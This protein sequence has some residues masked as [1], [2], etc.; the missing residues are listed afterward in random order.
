MGKFE[1]FSNFGNKI[2][3]CFLWPFLLNIVLHV[4]AN[5]KKSI[6]YRVINCTKIGTGHVK[7]SSQITEL[8]KMKFLKDIELELINNKVTGIYKYTHINGLSICNQ[9][10]ITNIL[11]TI[12]F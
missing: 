6:Y 3:K 1:C 7:V 8:W 2:K 9:K 4:F 10:S 5:G 12:I 11:V